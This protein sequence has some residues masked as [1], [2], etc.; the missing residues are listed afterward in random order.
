[1]KVELTV[2]NRGAIDW[3]AGIPKKLQGPRFK[4]E[5]GRAVADAGRKT[6]TRV[7]RKVKQQ[8]GFRLARDVS[9]N[10]QGV[11]ELGA[12]RYRIFSNQRGMT[13]GHYK[14]LRSLKRGGIKTGIW[15]AP[16]TFESGYAESGRYFIPKGEGE[17]RRIT[18]GHK[19][20]QPRD[21]RGRFAVS[22]IKYASGRHELFGPA[23][24]SELGRD[25]SLREFKTFA[26]AELGRQVQKRI[27]KLLRY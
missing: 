14:G 8:G 19:P 23:V 3:F 18:F 27:T 21:G 9:Q 20:N 6:K 2:R 4:R 24:R 16:R 17:R 1:M 5:L 13:L 10:T 15:N 11:S 7:Q 25:D 26:P 22:K 12:L